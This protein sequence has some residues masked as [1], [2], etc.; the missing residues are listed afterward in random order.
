MEVIW[1]R[2]DS[3]KAHHS[4]LFNWYSTT[5]GVTAMCSAHNTQRQTRGHSLRCSDFIVVQVKIRRLK[6]NESFSI[7]IKITF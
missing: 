1:Q 5:S 7:L 4:N 3:G 2:E 6:A